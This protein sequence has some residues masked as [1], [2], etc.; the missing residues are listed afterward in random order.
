[1][2]KGIIYPSIEKIIGFNVLALSLLKAKKADKAQVLST[3]KLRVALDE[4]KNTDEDVHG[5]AAA[6][7]K[8]IVQKHPFASGNR[9][10][11]FIA[12]KYFALSN[13]GRFNIEDNPSHANA[14]KGVREGYYTDD[15]IKEWI[16]HGKIR[17]FERRA[18]PKDSGAGNP[19]I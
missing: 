7:L 14:M 15:E 9:R 2:G 18:N 10:T 5:K 8:G 16:M 6:L 4:C 3:S 13:G 17:E 1:M 12:A 19:K 11:A